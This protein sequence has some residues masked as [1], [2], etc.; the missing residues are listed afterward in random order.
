MDREIIK[1]I[2][3]QLEMLSNKYSD[4]DVRLAFYILH[5]Y[6]TFEFNNYITGDELTKIN[7]ELKRKNTMFDEDF[8]YQVDMILNENR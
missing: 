2:I 1:E 6:G 3:N 5:R 7:K 4:D 8:N